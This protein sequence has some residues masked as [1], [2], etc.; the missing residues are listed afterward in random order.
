MAKYQSFAALGSILEASLQKKR[1]DIDK[2]FKALDVSMQSDLLKE[3]IAQQ[4][5][6]NELSAQKFKL[7]SEVTLNRM[8]NEKLNRYISLENLKLSEWE[9]TDKKLDSLEAQSLKISGLASDQFHTAMGTTASEDEDWAKDMDDSLEDL[10]LSKGYRTKLLNASIASSSGNY[11]PTSML[12]EDI[13]L[14]IQQYNTDE[15]QVS[16][17]QKEL[18]KFYMSQGVI[19]TD[20]DDEGSPIL[21]SSTRYGNIFRSTLVSSENLRNIQKERNELLSEDDTDIQTNINLA[22]YESLSNELRSLDLIEANN[23]LKELQENILKQRAASEEGV[24]VDEYDLNQSINSLD[25]A[26]DAIEDVEDKIQDDRRRIQNLKNTGSII[27]VDVESQI[28]ELNKSIEE[29]KDSLRALNVTR[30]KAEY[31]RDIDYALLHLKKISAPDNNTYP[32]NGYSNEQ[33]DKMLEYL[34]SAVASGRSGRRLNRR[35]LMQ[36]GKYIGL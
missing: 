24:S 17:E 30:D 34:E 21:T 32:E 19:T 20:V 26:E 9:A 31:D 15:T 27:G 12:I 18:I 7:E 6:E 36:A 28:K 13:D 10:G 35:E 1:A 29:N 33:I 16:P 8:R 23:S 4:S 14:A 2:A 5:W 11:M 25:A 22:E 3:K